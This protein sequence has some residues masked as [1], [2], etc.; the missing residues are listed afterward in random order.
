MTDSK[1]TQE[2]AILLAGYLPRAAKELAEQ[3]RIELRERSQST[4]IHAFPHL[5]SE[6][7]LS[8]L[9]STHGESSW[10]I[11]YHPETKAM[12]SLHNAFHT[13]SHKVMMPYPLFSALNVSRELPG[14]A[15]ALQVIVDGIERTEDTA[16]SLVLDIP[17]LFLIKT[18][19][20]AAQGLAQNAALVLGWPYADRESIEEQGIEP[21]VETLQQVYKQSTYAFV[22]I[23][24]QTDG[25]QLLS[26]IKQK[27]D[28]SE[29]Y[30][31]IDEAM[32]FGS[33]PTP[34]ERVRLIEMA[35]A[36][37]AWM[38]EECQKPKWID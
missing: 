16:S 34:L 27:I 19:V 22:I 21:L 23:D 37:V 11:I 14:Y 38:Y 31:E 5:P 9:I 28:V 32:C 4:T 36:I 15:A 7:S 25:D 3:L 12:E 2:H 26:M 13:V 8:D 6:E 10:I 35:K 30:Q 24:V 18:P 33:L 20:T 29:R 1:P 17:R